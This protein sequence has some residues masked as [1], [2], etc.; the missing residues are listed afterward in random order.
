M[1]FSCYF[2]IFFI[3]FFQFFSSII[4]SFFFIIIDFNLT[5]MQSTQ[6]DLTRNKWPWWELYDGV[7]AIKSANIFVEGVQGFTKEFHMD[8]FQLPIIFFYHWRKVI[9]SKSQKTQIC[10]GWLKP[11]KNHFQRSRSLVLG[12]IFFCSHG[13]IWHEVFTPP[14]DTQDI[15]WF[16]R[17]GLNIAIC[18]SPYKFSVTSIILIFMLQKVLGFPFCYGEKIG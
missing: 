7:V 12:Q 2:M 17:R 15:G 6:Y 18:D 9:R 4:H 11:K 13:K 8:V 16:Y 3:Y 1:V 5:Y 14:I 10:Q